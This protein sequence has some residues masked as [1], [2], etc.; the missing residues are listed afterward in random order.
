MNQ[1][2]WTL[3]NPVA[4]VG[5][6][7]LKLAPRVTDLKG[8]T[9]GLLWNGKPNGDIFLNEVGDLLRGRIDGLKIVRLW[10]VRPDTKTVYGSSEDVMRSAA[11]KA[12]LI[13]CGSAD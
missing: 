8:K 5:K 12:D 3:M 6:V 11:E 9:I 10:E 13:I 1:A 2:V 4:D 7:E